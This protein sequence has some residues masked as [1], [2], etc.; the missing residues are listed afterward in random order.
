MSCASR[1][2]KE[3]EDPTMHAVPSWEPA[4][5]APPP[6]YFG[7]LPPPQR[8]GG[9]EDDSA[10]NCSRQMARHILTYTNR[11]AWKT[12]EIRVV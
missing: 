1:E 6:N 2:R 7:K 3:W 8:G 4:R 12:Y 5:A 10:T 9:E 11:D